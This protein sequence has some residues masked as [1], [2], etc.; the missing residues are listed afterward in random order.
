MSIWAKKWAYEQRTGQS[1]AKA[2]LVALA[3]FADE[4]GFCFPSQPTLAAMT[5]IAERTV[6]AHLKTLEQKG[7]IAREHRR[8]GGGKWTSDGY[9]L[10]AESEQ[11]KPPA[12]KSAA[13]SQRP[14]LP[15]AE[16]ASGKI[17][18]D[19]RQNQPAAK[20]AA[21]PSVES[22]IEPSV[23]PSVLNHIAS[24]KPTRA[25]KSKI[26]KVSTADPRTKHPAIQLVRSIIGHLPKLILY[27]KIISSLG[28]HP[29][30]K[31]A[32]ECATE[33]A[34]RGWNVENLNTWLFDWYLNGISERNGNETSRGNG[35]GKGYAERS[36]GTSGDHGQPPPANDR[37]RTVKNRI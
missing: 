10:L 6:R 20:S 28:K 30:G 23:E 19:G 25:K 29:D 3:E 32:V 14:N 11:L 35:N 7:F 1:G 31:K 34:S 5:E 24:D 4:T 15:E 12:A 27:D 22:D 13:R 9:M 26:E 16:S 17:S 36:Y 2:V 18:Q 8:V 33:C 37:Q 21:K